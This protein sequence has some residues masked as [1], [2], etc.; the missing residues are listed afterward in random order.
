MIRRILQAKESIELDLLSAIDDEN[1]FKIVIDSLSHETGS[2][3]SVLLETVFHYKSDEDSARKIWQDILKNQEELSCALKRR[4]GIK[5]AV[6]DYFSSN[7]M[8]ERILIFIKESMAGIID[9]ATRDGLTGVYT[10]EYIRAELD[11]EFLRAKR[12]SLPLSLL[13]IDIDDFKRFNDTHGH[14]AGDI[15]LETAGRVLR[16][17]IRQTDTLGRYGGEEFMVIL[18]HT[19]RG[20]ALKIARKIAGAVSASTSS[21][22]DLPEGVTVSIGVAELLAGMGN[23]NELIDAAD[24]AMYKAKLQGK[25]RC[26]LA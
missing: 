24:R 20:G 23:S 16:E 6:V 22:K 2:P 12:Y 8:D 21:H 19:V 9:A 10:H 3:H 25:N 5:T 15:A 11:K 1:V 7:G 17:N 13:F 14:K 26:C 4:V 18:P